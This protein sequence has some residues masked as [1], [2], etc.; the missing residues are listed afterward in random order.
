MGVSC[1]EES[2]KIMAG[3]KIN[4]MKLMDYDTHKVYWQ[5][6]NWDNTVVVRTE[7]F[8]KDILKCAVISRTLNFSSDEEIHDFSIVQQVTMDE[9]V[10]EELK[11]DFG[12]VIPHSTNDWE[13]IIEAD[14]ENMMSAEQINGKIAMD[15]LFM[16]K[17]KLLYKARIKIIYE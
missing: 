2:K 9:M 5:A 4:T 3:F 11:F 16:K 17:D 7:K 8:P 15:T 1:D 10:I 14:K 13:Q 6:S 12:F